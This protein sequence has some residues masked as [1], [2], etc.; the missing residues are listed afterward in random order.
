MDWQRLEA[1]AL[2]ADGYRVQR[3]RFRGD[4]GEVVKT[5]YEAWPPKPANGQH[6]MLGIRKTAKEAQALCE[7][8]EK[9]K[10]ND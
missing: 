10:G 2:V 8:H 4:Q 1:D 7:A 9:G 6:R 5:H 3:Y